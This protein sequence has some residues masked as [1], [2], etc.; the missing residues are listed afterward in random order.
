M[1]KTNHARSW[2]GGKWCSACQMAKMSPQ[3]AQLNTISCIFSK[4]AF[5][6]EKTYLKAGTRKED[7]TLVFQTDYRL[8]LV[9]V[10]QNWAFSNTFDLH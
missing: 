2:G 9:K 8:M 4:S 1:Q 6:V 3:D 7:K 10:L 5:N